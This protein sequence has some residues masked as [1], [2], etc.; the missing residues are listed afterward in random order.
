M[1]QN[2]NKLVRDLISNKIKANGEIPFIRI[3][4]DEEFKKELESKLYE[5][6]LE[7]IS[8]SGK[9]RLEEI[10]DML[11][12]LKY[13]AK[14]ENSSLEEVMNIG[15]KKNELRGSFEKRIYLER[16]RTKE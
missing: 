12:V 16:V 13:L 11:E 7:V 9:D 3:L 2:Y 14:I 4:N 15:L 6:Y 8:S 1:D 10:A 5:E